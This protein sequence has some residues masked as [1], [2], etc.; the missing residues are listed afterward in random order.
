M[1]YIM[2]LS[3]WHPTGFLVPVFFCCPASQGPLQPR[4]T[5]PKHLPHVCSLW[6]ACTVLQP[7]LLQPSPPRALLCTCPQQAYL[8]QY[9]ILPLSSTAWGLEYVQGLV[10]ICGFYICQS[11]INHFY[12]RESGWA[13]VLIS[14][15][16]LQLGRW[17]LITPEIWQ[18]R[19]NDTAKMQFVGSTQTINCSAYNFL[20]VIKKS[21]QDKRM[22]IST[23]RYCTS[24]TFNIIQLGVIHIIDLS[25]L[26]PNKWVTI[27]GLKG[28]K[29]QPLPEGNYH[30]ASLSG[31]SLPPHHL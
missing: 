12:K 3:L 16:K 10:D 7:H 14:T 29:R 21:V 1:K 5:N 23:R 26:T 8:A 18:K 22:S 4:E 9:L 19:Y 6:P 20:S 17:L 30:S 31:R 2:V 11:S 25:H 15:L 28:Q 24:H 27:S 13:M